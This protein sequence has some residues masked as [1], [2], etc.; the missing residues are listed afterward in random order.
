VQKTVEG[1]QGIGFY[2]NLVLDVKFNLL[3]LF[4]NSLGFGKGFRK[5]VQKTG[6]SHK[7]KVAFPKTEVLEKPLLSRNNEQY[8][9]FPTGMWQF[10]R[11]HDKIR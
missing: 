2:S 5:T 3:S 9:S 8:L 4:Q 6:F 10:F 11:L 1:P 7:S